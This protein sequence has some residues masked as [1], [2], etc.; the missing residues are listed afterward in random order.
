MPVQVPNKLYHAVQKL[1][2][3]EAF[4]RMVQ[5]TTFE[6]AQDALSELHSLAR[7]SFK[8]L[9]R[10]HHPDVGGELTA[11]QELSEAFEV[12]KQ[13]K[14]RR[15]VPRPVIR[16]INIQAWGSNLYNTS[17]STTGTGYW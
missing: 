9:A 15:P 13:I 10:E 8:A 17:T 12:V 5:A 6:Y 1:G 2:L 7:T 16:I 11:M 14:L 3:L 4:T